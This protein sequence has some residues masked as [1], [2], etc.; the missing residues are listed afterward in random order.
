MT[1]AKRAQTR[2]GVQGAIEGKVPGTDWHGESAYVRLFN[3]AK[4]LTYVFL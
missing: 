4:L 1:V 3:N 2:L